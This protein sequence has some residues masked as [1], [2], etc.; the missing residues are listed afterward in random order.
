M[1]P[2]L[3][4][5]LYLM[6]GLLAAM[7]MMV[8]RLTSANRRTVGQSIDSLQLQIKNLADRMESGFTRM[9][10]RLEKVDD[11]VRDLQMDM[12]VV[13]DRLNIPT[14]D[15]P[16]SPPPEP[17]RPSRKQPRPSLVPLED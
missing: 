12:A 1:D 11:R 4:N 13:K 17:G 6:G 16:A 2:D 15:R 5:N 3:L 8:W 14:G 10:D 9:E 7:F